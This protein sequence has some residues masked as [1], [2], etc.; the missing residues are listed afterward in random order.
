MGPIQFKWHPK[1]GAIMPS[2]MQQNR[3]ANAAKRVFKNHS[4][5]VAQKG[6]KGS[7]GQQTRKQ[8]AYAPN[9]LPYA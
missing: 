7:F 3:A 4:K 9:G 2:L 6:A 8:L 1:C 5:L